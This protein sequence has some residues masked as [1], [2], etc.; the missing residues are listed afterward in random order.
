MEKLA[1]VQLPVNELKKYTSIVN[2]Q[3]KGLKKYKQGKGV[4][5]T[6]VP[7][8]ADESGETEQKK[9]S[10]IAGKKRKERLALLH[11]FVVKVYWNVWRF[12]E[13]YL[14]ISTNVLAKFFNIYT[15]K[16]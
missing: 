16:S 13:R 9:W 5:S 11:G 14:G 15:M 8:A 10:S 12:Y 1:S 4:E 6:H 7:D 2:V 3:T